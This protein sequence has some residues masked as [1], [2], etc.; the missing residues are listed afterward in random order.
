MATQS[1]YHLTYITAAAAAAAPE[2]FQLFH[3]VTLEKVRKNMENNK[4]F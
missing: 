3:S 1:L 4:T 2:I